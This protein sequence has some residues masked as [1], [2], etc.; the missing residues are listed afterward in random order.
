VRSGFMH[1]PLLPEQALAHPGL[2]AMPLK[3]MVRGTQLALDV[4]LRHG[5]GDRALAGGSIA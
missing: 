5:P 2:P 1:V 3:D 4:A